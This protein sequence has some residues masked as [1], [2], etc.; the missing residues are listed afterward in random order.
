MDLFCF[1]SRNS[2]NIRRGYAA[3]KWAVAMVSQ[4]A[5][6]GRITKAR[7]YFAAGSHGLLYC[8]PTH[9]FTVPFVAASAAD[10]NGVVTDIWPVFTIEPLGSPERQLHAGEAVIRWPFLKQRMGHGGVTAALN[11]TGATA[12]VPVPIEPDDWKLI[13]RDLADK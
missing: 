7:K 9:S 12:F 2:E 4:P 8:R 5:M 10:Q 1:A 3:G 11:A 6:R 13:L